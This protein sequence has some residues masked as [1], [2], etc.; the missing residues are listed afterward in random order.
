MIF[1]NPL[2]GTIYGANWKRPA[3]SLAF[4]VTQDFGPTSVT[5][6]PA[7]S[8][9]GGEG[10]SAGYYA[11][12]HRGDDFGNGQC[13]AAVVAAQAGIVRISQT[14]PS[15]ASAG[16][17]IVAIDHGG[18][19]WTLYGHLVS[20]SV[21]VNAK[22]IQGQRVGYVGETGLASACHLHFA[23]KDQMPAGGNPYANGVGRWRDPWPR[24]A[25]NVTLSIKGPGVNIRVDQNLGAVYAASKDDGLIHRASDNASL[26][27]FSAQHPWGGTVNGA[28][29]TVNG[30]TGKTWEKLYLDG[31]W[32]YIA[33]P[34]AMLSAS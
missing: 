10:I 1:G 31:G 4:K 7:L 14:V 34:L 28:N 11:H 27:A 12:F 23:V 32:R 22:V 21:A 8:W 2:R 17:N 15:G 20:R 19:W 24:L 25:Q 26:G 16:E 5:A 30:V 13:G 9:P 6:E 18:G 3:G 33:T 29:Y